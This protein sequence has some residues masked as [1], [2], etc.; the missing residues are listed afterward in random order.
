MVQGIE[1]TAIASPDPH[2]LA[3]W[4]V[5]TLGFVINYQSK[6]S[7]TVFVKAEN[8]TMIEIIEAGH[9]ASSPAELNDPGLRHLALTVGDFDAACQRLRSL[10]VGFLSEPSTRG[11]NS[12]VF[13]R[14][15][16]GNILHLLHR[17]KP[18]E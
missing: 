9:P 8:G 3:Q 18:L 15:P 5:D 4:Y 11:G 12:L 17:E 1:H 16:D 7:R 6:T 14:D 13:F 2:R 10:G